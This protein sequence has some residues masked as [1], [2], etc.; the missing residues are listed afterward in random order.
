MLTLPSSTIIPTQGRNV[1]F[2]LLRLESHWTLLI[3]YFPA[4]T[5]PFPGC[6]RHF[7]V[8]SNMRRHARIHGEA[9][10]RVPRDG[11]VDDNFEASTVYLSS[12][13]THNT[14]IIPQA[15]IIPSSDQYSRSHSPSSTSSSHTRSPSRVEILRRSYLDQPPPYPYKRSQSPLSDQ[16]RSSPEW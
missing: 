11:S 5:C 6:G 4:F 8:M 1:G 7:S 13:S 2:V 9:T 15:A 10:I 12:S 16:G 3:C 14:P